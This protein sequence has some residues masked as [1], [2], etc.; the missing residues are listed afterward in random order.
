[1]TATEGESSSRCQHCSARFATDSVVAGTVGAGAGG[2][3][4]EAGAVAAA[5]SLLRKSDYFHSNLVTVSRQATVGSKR[6]KPSGT[7]HVQATTQDVAAILLAGCNSIDEP[8]VSFLREVWAKEEED[9]APSM[10]KQKPAAAATG[11]TG[12]SHLPPPPK[13]FLDRIAKK[14]SAGGD[15]LLLAAHH[16]EGRPVYAATLDERRKLQ[17]QAVSLTSSMSISPITSTTGP[18]INNS[19]EAA[20]K[21]FLTAYSGADGSS[22]LSPTSAPGGA[23][24]TSF[25]LSPTATASSSSSVPALGLGAALLAHKQA[26]C[27]SLLSID[28][29]GEKEA[30]VLVTPVRLQALPSRRCLA[31]IARGDPGI[32]T[33]PNPS[34]LQLIQNAMNSNISN[35]HAATSALASMSLGSWFR[36]TSPASALVPR[37]QVLSR[38][39]AS[40]DAAASVVTTLRVVN[41]NEQAIIVALMA[42]STVVSTVITLKGFDELGLDEEEE[43]EETDAAGN[44][45]VSRSIVT[46]LLGDGDDGGGEI[47]LSQAIK[48]H[49]AENET[50]KTATLTRRWKHVVEFQLTIPT[51][52]LSSTSSLKMAFFLPNE[53]LTHRYGSSTSAAKGEAGAGGPKQ[54]GKWV[55]VDHRLPFSHHDDE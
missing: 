13:P 52:P 42:S 38:E 26:F 55:I 32:L 22:I 2:T 54:K 1:M 4:S 39:K 44:T 33:S 3:V 34:P 19:I 9:L 15:P 47:S 7:T 8:P 6:H 11:K 5:V 36:K 29:D 40:G 16:I 14:Y 45:L 10:T 49:L 24:G 43:E 31:C 21:K 18:T 41:P 28:D 17:T 51:T 12:P 20:A 23:A 46:D 53:A 35:P 50:A 48:R 27:K 30:G 37:L 25:P